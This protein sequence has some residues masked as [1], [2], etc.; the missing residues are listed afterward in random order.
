VTD[1]LHHIASVSGGKDSTALWLLAVERGVEIQPVF[2]DTGHE[3]TYEYLADL[4][5]AEFDR[6]MAVAAWVRPGTGSMM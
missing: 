4:P 3:Q 2:A 6:A 5:A 1:R